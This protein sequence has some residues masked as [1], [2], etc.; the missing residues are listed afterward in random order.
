MKRATK[1]TLLVLALVT[2]G[3]MAALMREAAENPAFRAADYESLGE[4]LRNIPAEWLDGSIE[5]TGAET[6]CRHVHSQAK[7]QR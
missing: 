3:I 7:G 4:C 2:I 1:L 6:A 5:R